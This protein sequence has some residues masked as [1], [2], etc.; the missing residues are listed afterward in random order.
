M[1]GIFTFG[2][3]ANEE[4]VNHIYKPSSPPSRET[5]ESTE[6]RFMNDLVN[7][8]ADRS[9]FSTDEKVIGRPELHHVIGFKDERPI[10]LV[11]IP[12]WCDMIIPPAMML[13]PAALG[14]PVWVPTMQMEVLFKAIPKG[15]EVFCKFISRYIINGRE[16]MDGELFDEDGT[17]IA[18]T[19]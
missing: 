2:N 1:T 15:K 19:R 12:F 7:V 14:G 18:L 8:S 6:Y 11:S 16:E 10:D 3:F 5:L 17:L 9:A 13:G 4:G